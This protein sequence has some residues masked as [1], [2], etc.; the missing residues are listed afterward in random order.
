MSIKSVT[1]KKIRSLRLR[2]ATAIEKEHCH[3]KLGNVVEEL[4]KDFIFQCT[5]RNS[6]RKQN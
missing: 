3:K 1:I 4:L 2:V 6:K 5:C